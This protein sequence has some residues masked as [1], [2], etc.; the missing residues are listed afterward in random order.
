MQDAS[1]RFQPSARRGHSQTDQV[2]AEARAA[3]KQYGFGLKR[4]RIDDE[5]PAGRERG[6]DG[7]EHA[8]ITGATADKDRLRWRQSGER[9]RG[10]AVYDPE[11]WHP[12]RRRIAGDAR[13]AIRARLDGDGAQRRVS[14]HPFDADRA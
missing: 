12:K 1:R 13:G 7:I 10:R 2:A 4:D 5:A 3:G 6:N 11:P 14:E 9:P 8:R